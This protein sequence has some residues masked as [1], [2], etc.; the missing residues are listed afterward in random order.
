MSLVFVEA[1]KW[2]VTAV[3][4][5]WVVRYIPQL[6]DMKMCKCPEKFRSKKGTCVVSLQQLEKAPVTLPS[7]REIQEY[8]VRRDGQTEKTW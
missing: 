4:I 6:L 8:S 2:G 1:G 3:H 7:I 5:I